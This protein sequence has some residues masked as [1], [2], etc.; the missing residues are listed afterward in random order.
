MIT[1]TSQISLLE[2][3][4]L[5]KFQMDYNFNY[6]GLVPSKLV[7]ELFYQSEEGCKQSMLFWQNIIK[8]YN[9]LKKQKKKGGTKIPYIYNGV[10]MIYKEKELTLDDI[11]KSI[12][13]K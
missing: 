3:T 12:K 13:W 6:E 9:K 11:F 2:N 1:H 10:I 5:V 7:S 4:E 8:E